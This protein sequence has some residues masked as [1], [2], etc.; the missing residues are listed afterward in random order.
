[1]TLDTDIPGFNPEWKIDFTQ[2]LTRTVS[3]TRFS[4]ADTLS[5][6][7]F[8]TLNTPPEARV[9]PPARHSLLREKR[10][11]RRELRSR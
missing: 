8:E 11:Q 6:S 1:V 4:G 3:A 2:E 5:S 9:A 7:V 10:A